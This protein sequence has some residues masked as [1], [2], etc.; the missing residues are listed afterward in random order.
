METIPTQTILDEIVL[1]K[2]DEVA[3]LKRRVPLHRVLEQAEHAP[4][5]KDFYAALKADG[6]SLIA[7]VKRASPSKGLL[8]DELDPGQFADTYVKNGA[9]AISV[10]TDQHYFQGSLADFVAVRRVV[11][12]PMLRKDF[13]FDPY[14]VY[15]A[16]AAGADAVLLI[17]A[18]LNDDALKALYHLVVQLGME[19]LV[20]V[21]NTREMERALMIKPDIIGI[22]NRDLHT[23]EVNLHTTANL[24]SMLPTGVVIVA[25][26]GIHTFHDVEYLHQLGAHAMLVGE[27]LVTAPDV[28]SKVRELCGFSPMGETDD[29][30]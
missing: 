26:S 15:E 10:L 8:R 16:R 27:A 29:K 20:E 3:N 28:G 24:I 23:F 25:E 5:P 19:A 30:D 4:S 17:T 9:A 13:I 11:K 21:H 12:V 2:R 7:E 22:N 14:Q 18:I 1:H 6:V